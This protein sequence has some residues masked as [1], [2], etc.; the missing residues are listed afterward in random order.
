LRP[1]D[2][3]ED[4][5]PEVII[6]GFGRVGQI[7]G[8]LLFAS[9][10]RAT[11]LDQDPEQVDSL[12]RFGFQVY[13]G[14][15][16]RLELL[17]AAGART[18][19]VIVIAVDDV[20]AVITIATMVKEH[21]PHLKI[22]AR[23]RNVAEVYRLM[24]LGVQVWERETFDGSLRLGTE[25]LREVGWSPYRA[26]RAGIVFRRH[27]IRLLHE[28]YKKRDDQREVISAVKQSR[29]DLQKMFIGEEDVI[30]RS[31]EDWGLDIHPQGRG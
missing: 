30:R 6:A 27:N 28:L 10:I 13:Y 2:E 20:D 24:D 1:Q 31:E 5:H 8:R 9:R 17:E 11:I 12:R 15:A 29:D 3:I 22:V 25:V 7:I 19:K 18:A 21:F 16:T 23:A 4:S 26:A 14:N